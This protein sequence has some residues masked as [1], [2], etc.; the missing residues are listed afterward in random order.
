MLLNNYEL[1]KKYS[2]QGGIFLGAIFLI[3]KIIDLIIKPIKINIFGNYIIGLPQAFL[4]GFFVGVI[5]AIILVFVSSVSQKNSIRG[6]LV[7]FVTS[8]LI[9][10]LYYYIPSSIIHYGD[11]MNFVTNLF[12]GF[13]PI[14][15]ISWLIWL[16]FGFLIGFL[17]GKFIQEN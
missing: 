3:L 16:I 7:G 17:V 1:Y 10:P 15:L 8:I 12:F 9:I 11:S 5:L 6:G 13:F 14:M 2:I 4:Y